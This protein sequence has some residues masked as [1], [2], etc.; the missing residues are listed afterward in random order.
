V[1]ADPSTARSRFVLATSLLV[2]AALVPAAGDAGPSSGLRSRARSLS[3]ANAA[4]AVRSRGAVLTL[5]SLDAQLERTRTRLASLEAQAAAVARERAKTRRHLRVARQV[6]TAAQQSLAA[7]LRILYEEGDTNP[8]EVLLGATSLDQALSSLETLDVS[9]SADRRVIAQ[10]RAG[11]AAYLRVA[12]ALAARDARLRTLEA[13]EQATAASLLAARSARGAYIRRLAAERRLN[14][15]K[16]ASLEAE[17]Q[18]VEARARQLAVAQAA[19]PP[20]VG[21]AVPAPPALDVAA[22]R[23]MTVTATGYSLRGNTATGAPVGYGVVAVDPSVIPLGTRMTVPGYG[24]GVA[25][26]TGGAVRGATIDL[27]F[28]SSADAAAWGRRTVTITLH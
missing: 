8:L 1:R 4:L 27:W 25:A 10:A 21:G 16:I 24:E 28:P 9:A 23:T 17:A 20:A 7:R 18:A 15:A 5:Y 11:R 2:L 12:K 19:S 13:R 26:D 3:Q 14:A 6:L 22:G